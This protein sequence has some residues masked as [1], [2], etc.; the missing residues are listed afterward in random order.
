[1]HPSG[2]GAKCPALTEVQACQ[3]Q[4]CPAANEDCRYSSWNAWSKC[5]KDCT[6]ADG[7]AGT[8]SRERIV[9][10]EAR[11]TGAAC[12]DANKLEERA[13]GKNACVAEPCQLGAWQ[14]WNACS[15]E[16][17]GGTQKRTKAVVVDAKHGGTCD[18]LA[19]GGIEERECNKAACAVEPTFQMLDEVA[20]A[21]DGLDRVI[22]HDNSGGANVLWSGGKKLYKLA[23][24]TN[25]KWAIIGNYD[26]APLTSISAVTTDAE[27][28]YLAGKYDDNGV[29]KFQL[30]KVNKEGFFTQRPPAV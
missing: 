3:R 8:Q 28:I 20:L 12:S 27:F 29:Q 25:G 13:C 18:L 24:Q 19:L 2:T 30:H 9:L 15:R 21:D 4:A 1:M 6:G 22:V 7:V 23:E 17:G 26:P 11:G 16:C 5:T 14:T 10:Q